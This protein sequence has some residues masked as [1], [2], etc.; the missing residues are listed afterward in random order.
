MNRDALP[1]ILATLIPADDEFGMPSAAEIDFV[2]YATTNAAWGMSM[3]FLTSLP[4]AVL[5]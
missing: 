1:L 5:H 3:P 2:G 4:K